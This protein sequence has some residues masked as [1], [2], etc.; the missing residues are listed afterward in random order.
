MRNPVERLE[1]MI[2]LYNMYG[3]IKKPDI[4]TIDK[5]RF[6]QKNLYIKESVIRFKRFFNEIKLIDFAKIN[7]DQQ[8]VY[9]QILNFLDLES[10]ELPVLTNAEVHRSQS[11]RNKHIALFASRLNVLLRTLGFGFIS[12]YAKD[13]DIIRNIL[14]TNQSSKYKTIAHDY[15][16]KDIDSFN[17][18]KEFFDKEFNYKVNWKV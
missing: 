11:P 13:S 14:F 17:E 6:F 5:I 12:D 10:D 1:S 18:E 4:E 2:N 3:R 9:D 8:G 7:N 15:I 16:K